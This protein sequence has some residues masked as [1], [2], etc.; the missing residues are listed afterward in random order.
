MAKRLPRGGFFLGPAFGFLE[1]VEKRLEV[2][3][4]VVDHLEGRQGVQE[5]RGRPFAELAADIEREAI[6][7]FSGVPGHRFKSLYVGLET[8][9][10]RQ[11]FPHC[12]IVASATGGYG[13]I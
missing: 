4:H 2:A 10:L 6:V 9:P 11:W 5:A 13:K 3:G 8:P 1:L 7:P 12:T